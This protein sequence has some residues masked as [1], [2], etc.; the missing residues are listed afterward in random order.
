MSNGRTMVVWKSTPQSIT[1]A[2]IVSYHIIS[3][4]DISDLMRRAWSPKK[5]LEEAQFTTNGRAMTSPPDQGLAAVDIRL[6]NERVG[7]PVTW[8]IFAF[9][10]K[11]NDDL[12]S[13]GCSIHSSA[14]AVLSAGT[15]LLDAFLIADCNCD[16]Q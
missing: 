7:I 10:E 16:A 3:Y 4:D 14:E 11:A 5:I 2:V 9:D 13:D 1:N 6:R 8:T 15:L 12:F